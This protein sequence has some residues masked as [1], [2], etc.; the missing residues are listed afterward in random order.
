MEH[1]W[2]LAQHSWNIY[3]LFERK[4]I[5]LHYY[6]CEVPVHPNTDLKNDIDLNDEGFGVVRNWVNYAIFISRYSF[7]KGIHSVYDANWSLQRGIVREPSVV[8]SAPDPEV[9]F[10]ER[11]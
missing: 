5:D 3:Q 4:Q 11:I 2:R 10:L 7:T 9:T 8:G 6:C 1:L